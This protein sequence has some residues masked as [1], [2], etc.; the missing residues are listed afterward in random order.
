MGQHQQ[1]VETEFNLTVDITQEIQSA[2]Q[3]S[4]FSSVKKVELFQKASIA[5]NMREEHVC[6]H[7]CRMVYSTSSKI[8]LEL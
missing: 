5:L 1:N 4:V 8:K 7:N 2:N 3:Y 6:M